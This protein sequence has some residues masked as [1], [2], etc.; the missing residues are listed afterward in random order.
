MWPRKPRD[1]RIS[2]EIRFHRDRLIEDYVAAGMNRRDAER[3]VFLEFGNTTQIEEDVRDARGRWL[4]DLVK[5]LGYALRTLRRTPAFAFV[6]VISLALG[7]GANTAIFS[8]VNAIMLQ[9]LPVHE[10]GRLVRI[11]RVSSYGKA[12]LVSYPIFEFFRK[13]GRAHV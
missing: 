2:D 7:I 12:A 5:D 11:G 6:A 4:D 9:T 1:P 8:L 10:S 13:I 3:R